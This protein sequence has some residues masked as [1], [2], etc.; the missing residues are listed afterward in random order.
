MLLPLVAEI[1]VGQPDEVVDF[2]AITVYR[3]TCY[4]RWEVKDLF[5]DFVERVGNK[6][7]TSRNTYG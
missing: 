4:E 3:G 6:M 2:I 5:L 7:I 1:G